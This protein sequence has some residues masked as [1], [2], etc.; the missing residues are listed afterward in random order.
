MKMMIFLIIICCFSLVLK[1]SEIYFTEY[2]SES[3]NFFIGTSSPKLSLKEAVDDAERDAYIRLARFLKTF[4]CSNVLENIDET[5]GINSDGIIERSFS[6]SMESK[7]TLN[8]N[9]IVKS[10]K[11]IKED[12]NCTA[13][14]KYVVRAWYYISDKQIILLRKEWNVRERE[15]QR[16]FDEVAGRY[17]HSNIVQEQVSCLK[18]MERLLSNYL[19]ENTSYSVTSVSEMLEVM[20]KTIGL[21]YMVTSNVLRNQELEAIKNTIEYVLQDNFQS[22]GYHLVK[23]QNGYANIV[24]GFIHNEDNSSNNTLSVYVDLCDLD[25][26][27]L[28]NMYNSSYNFTCSDSNSNQKVMTFIL[29]KLIGNDFKKQLFKADKIDQILRTN[30]T[31]LMK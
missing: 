9:Q 30:V 11:K 6:K 18:Q 19:I 12:I 16:K 17:E 14:Q 31:N 26:I 1:S 15:A 7:S 2:N 24:T 29:D 22:S 27:R 4:V 10:L 23:G 25:G 28:Y 5:T 13:G 8:T 21:T 3:E 20:K